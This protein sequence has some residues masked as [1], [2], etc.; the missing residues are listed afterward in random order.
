M[1]RR[2]AIKGQS[3]GANVFHDRG[4]AHIDLKTNAVENAA[5]LSLYEWLGMTP[6]AWEG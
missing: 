1:A 2:A 4:A 3:A 6:V 5:A